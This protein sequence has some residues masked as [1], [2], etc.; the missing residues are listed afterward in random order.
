MSPD[1][2]CLLP[3][4]L[5]P[6]LD[7]LQPSVLSQR[8]N[9]TSSENGHICNYPSGQ[10]IVSSLFLLSFY[11]LNLSRGL[12]QSPCISISGS[13]YRGVSGTSPGGK[14]TLSSLLHSFSNPVYTKQLKTSKSLSSLFFKSKMDYPRCKVYLFS[15]P[16]DDS[17][18][19]T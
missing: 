17:F 2:S 16:I 15:T 7:L 14:E 18:F 6:T 12:Y 1:V 3:S 4:V 13:T 19:L 10:F 11:H 8:K 9:P 5:S